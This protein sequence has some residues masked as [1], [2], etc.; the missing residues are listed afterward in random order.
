MGETNRKVKVLELSFGM[1]D[2]RERET[3]LCRKRFQPKPVK[4]WWGRGKMEGI[5]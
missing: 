5:T 4:A 1:E 2:D 3:Q